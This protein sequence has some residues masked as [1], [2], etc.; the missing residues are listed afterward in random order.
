MA[1]NASARGI[2][3]GALIVLL[4][5]AAPTALILLPLPPKSPLADALAFLT[6]CPYRAATHTP[7]PLCGGTTA[8]LALARGDLR[9]AISANALAVLVGPSL[10]LQLIFR[11]FRTLRPTFSWK[12]ELGVFAAGLGFGL[13]LLSLG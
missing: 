4:G 11:A 8:L 7:C 9:G 6:A 3:L 13:L 5:L 1:K 12:E 2:H 10:V